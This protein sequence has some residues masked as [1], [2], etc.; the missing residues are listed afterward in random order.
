MKVN[1]EVSAKAA[2]LIGRENI[3]DVDGALS[4]LI[5]NAYDADASCVYVDFQIPFPEVPTQT[6]PERFATVL[7]EGHLKEVLSYYHMTEGVL[8]RNDELPEGDKAKLQSILF[9]Y[10]RIVVADNGEGMTLDTVCSAWMQIATSS[11]ETQIESKK[12]RIKTGAKGIGRFALDKLSTRSVMYTRAQGGNALRWEVDW[13]QFTNAQLLREVQAEIEEQVAPLPELLRGVLDNDALHEIKGFSWETGTVFVLSPLREAWNAR[14]FEKVNTN[15]KSINPL[16]SVDQFTVIVR[17]RLL[18]EYSYRTEPM[19]IAEEDYDYRL[20]VHYDGQDTLKIKIIRNEFDTHKRNATFSAGGKEQQFPLRE[21]W[22]RAAFAQ[23]HYSKVEWSRGVQELDIPVDSFIPAEDKDN[24]RSVG[25]FSAE[26]YFIKSGKSDFSIVK[27]VPTRRRKALLKRF[28]GVKL[29]RNNF[30]VRPYGDVG[31]M[32]DWL[33]LDERANKSPAGVSHL[34]GVWHVRSYQLLGLVKIGREENPALYDMANREGLTQNESY[35]YFVRMLQEAIS[36][37]EYDRQYLYREYDRWKK[38][39]VKSMATTGEKVAEDVRK[40][41][42][43]ADSDKTDG[44]PHDDTEQQEQDRKDEAGDSGTRFSERDYREAVDGLLRE[45][46]RELKA[47]Q[48]LETVSSAGV[49]L[50]TFFHEFN[51]V[52]NELQTRGSQ[53]RARIDNLLDRQPYQGLEFLDPY[54][55][56]EDYER[57]DLMLGAWLKVVMQAIEKENLE[58]E[59]ISLLRET[60]KIATIWKQLLA[61]KRIN[62]QIY[63]E[64]QLDQFC[65]MRLAVVDLYVIINNFVLNAVWFLEKKAQDSRDI[66]IELSENEQTILMRME[67]NGPPL[68]KEYCGQPMRIFEIGESAKEPRGTGLGLFLVREVVER[69]DGLVRPL[70]KTDGFGIEIE[71]QK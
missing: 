29:Y 23:A 44:Q 59:E 30:K 67:N 37:F 20:D 63:P 17:N 60:N 12:G 53:M 55:K 57:I 61:E 39:C 5:K 69:T 54:K 18:P 40:H 51:G 26:L 65:M 19:S 48:T 32:F 14:L 43:N 56:L 8:Q 58:I 64:E 13:D 22:E 38:S 3:A 27:D 35:Y 45:K 15:L 24:I 62:I 71:W 4:E 16:G 52:S 6:K 49:I 9:S 70:E 25:P 33:G 41:G 11:K 66:R 46:K 2:R 34:T 28:S 68:A 42:V 10:D 47:K 50:N 1:F 31:G 36:R 21:F 7:T